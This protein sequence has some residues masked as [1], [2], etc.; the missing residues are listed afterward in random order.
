MDINSIFTSSS[1]DPLIALLSHIEVQDAH[2]DSIFRASHALFYFLENQGVS[3]GEVELAL[4]TTLGH[5]RLAHLILKGPPNVSD[6]VAFKIVKA[7]QKLKG[8][9]K[10]G[11]GLVLIAYPS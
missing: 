5:H 3:R 2:P 10:F 6:K 11:S 9:G 1:P 8:S 7:I 4:K